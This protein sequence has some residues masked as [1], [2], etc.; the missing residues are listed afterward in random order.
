MIG[1]LTLGINSLVWQTEMGHLMPL[2]PLLTLRLGNHS[3]LA[4]LGRKLL[5][6]AMAKVAFNST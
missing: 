4:D 2:K 6:S 1:Q 3:A 5:P